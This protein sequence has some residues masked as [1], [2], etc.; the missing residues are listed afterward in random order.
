MVFVCV[1]QERYQL[2][3]LSSL[4]LS[5]FKRWSLKTFK[6]THAAYLYRAT[7][8]IAQKIDPTLEGAEVQEMDRGAKGMRPNGERGGL[9]TRLVRG[10]TAS[11]DKDAA[12]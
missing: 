6:I 7:W 1:G 3:N 11:P 2:I 9:F 4:Y 12:H 5:I 10:L 8:L